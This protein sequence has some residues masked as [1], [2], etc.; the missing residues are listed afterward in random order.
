MQRLLSL[1]VIVIASA[2][3]GCEPPPP[4]PPKAPAKTKETAK[5][6]KEAAQAPAA[7]ALDEA[8]ATSQGILI[9]TFDNKIRIVLPAFMP[10]PTV[11]R[12]EDRDST[13]TRW[14]S[15]TNDGRLCLVGWNKMYPLFFDRIAK[16]SYL[17][18]AVRDACRQMGGTE[19]KEEDFTMRGEPCRRLWL[20]APAEE[21]VKV[22]AGAGSKESAATTGTPAGEVKGKTL[23]G[24]YEYIIAAP[25]FFQLA[26]QSPDPAQRDSPAVKAFF[27]SFLYKE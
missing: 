17:N 25:Y 4:P 2:I 23:Y 14:L 26:F 5:T 20:Q 21:A 16:D 10:A 19:E 22:A 8:V 1:I 7:A 3:L 11:M 18:I 27:E 6:A 24:R 15:Q 13:T 12:N 9:H